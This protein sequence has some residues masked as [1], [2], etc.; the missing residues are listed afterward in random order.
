VRFH[1]YP[2]YKLIV[3]SRNY[4]NLVTFIWLIRFS[5]FPSLSTYQVELLK[6]K[7]SQQF[8]FSGAAGLYGSI[9]IQGTGWVVKGKYPNSLLFLVLQVVRFI[10]IPN[11][12]IELL[13]NWKYPTVCLVLQV[14]QFHQ[15]PKYKL[16]CWNW[17]YQQFT[18]VGS[19]GL[20]RSIHYPVQG[21]LFE[22]KYLNSSLLF[23]SVGLAVPSLSH[24]SRSVG[25]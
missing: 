16:N 19:L 25:E 13:R 10:I 20:N 17:K 12:R 21:E 14:V 5:R 6:V 8:T 24:Y 11:Y 4:P 23:G 15:Y 7:V 2:K 9:S 3:E 22:S 1:H 18:F